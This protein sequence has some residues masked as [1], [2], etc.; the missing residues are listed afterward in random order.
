VHLSEDDSFKTAKRYIALNNNSYAFNDILDE[1]IY[2]VAVSLADFDGLESRL[3][4]PIPLQHY[5]ESSSQISIST[6]NVLGVVITVILVLGVLLG[7]LAVFIVR[8]RR[9]RMSF[10]NFASSHYSTSSGAATFQQS[11]EEEHD[12]PVIRGF[13]DD[14]PLLVA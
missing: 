11:M 12:S 10:L 13:S 2:W 3:S 8:H 1:K 14:E 6:S 7:T 5:P 9:L 4:V